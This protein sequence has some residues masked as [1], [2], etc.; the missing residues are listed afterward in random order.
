MQPVW[1]IAEC[2]PRRARE[3]QPGLSK[4]NP[5]GVNIKECRAE[6]CRK[7]GQQQSI[8][9]SVVCIAVGGESFAP[10]HIEMVT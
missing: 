3:T 2:W 4:A 9:I 1:V 10:A 5:R 6:G 8:G 7:S